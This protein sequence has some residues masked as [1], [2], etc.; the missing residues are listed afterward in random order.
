MLTSNGIWSLDLLDAASSRT[1]SLAAAAGVDATEVDSARPCALSSLLMLAFRVSSEPSV[2]SSALLLDSSAA[3]I[4][5]A[6][7]DIIKV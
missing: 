4:L 5:V 3:R 6:T 1:L 7:W 2:F